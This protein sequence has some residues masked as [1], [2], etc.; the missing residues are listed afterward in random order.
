MNLLHNDHML[1]YFN[2]SHGD[3]Q[4]YDIYYFFLMNFI[5]TIYIQPEMKIKINVTL[6]YIDILLRWKIIIHMY[7]SLL[8][9]NLAI[10]PCLQT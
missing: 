7:T 10:L 6:L 8:F 3:Y 2:V 1:Y 4:N 5:Q 9:S